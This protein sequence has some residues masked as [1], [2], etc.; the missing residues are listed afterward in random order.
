MDFD[1]FS[2]GQVKSKIWLAEKLEPYI[3]E[4]VAV[5]G[6]WH[7]LTAFI[8][9]TRG[10]NSNITGIDINPEVKDI[11]NKICN[12]WVFEGSVSNITG[13]VLEM[14]L[15]YDTIINCSSEHMQSGWFDNVRPGALVCIQSSNV[16]DPDYPWYIVTPSADIDSFKQK[17]NLSSTLFLD[18]L[19]IQYGDWGYD[20]YMLIGFK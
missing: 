7:N 4:H 15:E 13:N 17:Y 20:R 11:A 19:R 16:I 10:C 8:L 9:K 18:T 12:Y 2:H 6:S 3:G 5:L 14:P 1:S